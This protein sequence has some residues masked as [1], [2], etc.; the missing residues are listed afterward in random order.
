MCGGG[1]KKRAPVQAA[2]TTAP[3]PAAAS[4]SQAAAEMAQQRANASN[5]IS[6]TDNQLPQTF[7]SE[8][9]Q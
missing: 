1:S 4:R 9:A 8:L 2:P 6:N 7:G 3:D 5:I